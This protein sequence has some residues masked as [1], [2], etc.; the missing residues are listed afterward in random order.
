MSIVI[1]GASGQL[2]RRAAERLLERVPPRDVVL[3]TRRPEELA[4]LADRGAE[5]RRGDFDGAEMLRQAFAGGERLLLVSTSAV[6]RR[7]PQHRVAVDAAAAAGI[8]HVVYTSLS[9]PTADN[10]AEVT[11]EHKTTEEILRDSG[12]TW[13]FL[14]NAIYAEHQ[15]PGAAEAIA[16]GKLVDNRGDGRVAFVSRAD[17]AAAAVA[18]L[19]SDG[20]ENVVYDV[21]GPELLSS[22]DAA[23]LLGELAGRPVE[24][25]SVSDIELMERLRAASLPEERVRIATSL[26]TAV[27]TGHMDQL[28][29][30]VQD[31]TGRRPQ[32]LREVFEEHRGQLGL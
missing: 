18:V 10:P 27:R 19:T 3:V 23:A 20:H 9:G 17:C 31:L 5:V 8:G 6:G 1:S 30:A 21:T 28:S 26:G 15:V 32:S 7:V 13:T 4:Y 14:R 22:A 2:G 11:W 25:H 16:A 29:S 24:H 12:L